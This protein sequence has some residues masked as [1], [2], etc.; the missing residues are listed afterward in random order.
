VSGFSH[1]SFYFRRIEQLRAIMEA[2]GDADKQIWLM[3]FGWTTDRVH[4]AYA[5]YATTEERKAELI[6]QAFQF[7]HQHWAPWIGVMTLWT[8]ADPAWGPNDE[9]VWWAITNPNGTTRPAYDRLLRARQ[10]GELP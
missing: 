9:Q 3:E 1:A 10:S 7:A 4:P 5:W 8:I 2:H 6:V